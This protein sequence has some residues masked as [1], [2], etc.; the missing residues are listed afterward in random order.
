[1]KNLLLVLSFVLAISGSASA[2]FCLGSEQGIFTQG[3]EV[4]PSLAYRICNAAQPSLYPYTGMTS[5]Q[6]YEAYQDGV[7]TITYLG[8]DPADSHKSLYRVCAGGGEGIISII[9]TI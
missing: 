6:L 8:A 3:Q 2:H 9:D 7:V 1:M 4:T 5:A